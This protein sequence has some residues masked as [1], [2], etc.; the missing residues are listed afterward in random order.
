MFGDLGMCFGFRDLFEDLGT[1]LGFRG[2]GCMKRLGIRVVGASAKWI[3][4]L[5]SHMS[6]F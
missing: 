6:A 4:K 3:N 5:R 1:C 2:L